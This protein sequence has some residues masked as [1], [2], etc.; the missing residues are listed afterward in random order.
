MDSALR[1][2]PL[3]GALALLVRLSAASRPRMNS[4][5]GS[6]RQTDRKTKAASP[7]LRHA[8]VEVARMDSALRTSPLRGALAMLVRLSAASRPRMN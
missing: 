5:R 3:R 1:A 8:L 7:R 6:M 2:S 4:L